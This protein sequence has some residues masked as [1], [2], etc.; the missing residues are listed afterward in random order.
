MILAKIGGPAKYLI[1]NLASAVTTFAWYVISER[2]VSD[3]EFGTFVALY[4]LMQLCATVAGLRLEGALISKSRDH[5]FGGALIIVT[6]LVSAIF[7][8]AATFFNIFL[9]TKFASWD[10]T[11][12][13]LTQGLVFSAAL[14][15]LSTLLAADALCRDDY[16]GVFLAKCMSPILVLV[17]LIFFELDF[18]AWDATASEIMRIFAYSTG[19]GAVLALAKRTF[20]ERW[21]NSLKEF[22]SDFWRYLR[23]Y[24]SRQM[25]TTL[26]S[27]ATLNLQP[28]LWVYLFGP[29]VGGIYAYIKRILNFPVSL[30][31]RPLSHLLQRQSS[32][33][34][35]S[36]SHRV[37]LYL[38]TA[39]A[40]IYTILLVSWLFLGP[41]ILVDDWDVASSISTLIFISG[42]VRFVAISLASRLLNSLSGLATQFRWQLANFTAVFVLA[43][44]CRNFDIHWFVVVT[45][46]GEFAMY[47]IYTR[48]AAKELSQ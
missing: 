18:F 39:S 47:F 9:L 44:L 37:H 2:L 41:I 11:R 43:Y 42:A 34:P 5:A 13:T 3:A 32:S 24:V 1:L 35:G 33:S 22:H 30:L 7:L 46:L 38:A 45:A 10:E 36:V 28:A 26:L 21:I 20:H 15:A 31:A 48:L 4:G 8:S 16:I 17:C 12:L 40:L 25:P 27:S 29:E 14:V 23:I 6:V 19:A